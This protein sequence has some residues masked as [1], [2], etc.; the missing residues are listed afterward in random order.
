MKI[1][2]TAIFELKIENYRREMMIMQTSP[3]IAKAL[4]I[5]E[6]YMVK[7]ECVMIGV[8]CFAEIE[9]N[10]FIAF[11][12]SLQTAMQRMQI[13]PSYLWLHDQSRQ[14]YLLLIWTS[15]FSRPDMDDVWPVIV[16]LWQR[17]SQLPF[18]QLETIRVNLINSPDTQSRLCE[19]LHAFDTPSRDRH[20]HQR[21]FGAS[22]LS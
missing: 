21:S 2:R 16:R 6:K 17:Y 18:R 10:R 20:H 22:H 1:Y 13:L 9:R 14:C 15:S 8:Y 3:V 4:A 12:D 7:W 5:T 11:M 19:I